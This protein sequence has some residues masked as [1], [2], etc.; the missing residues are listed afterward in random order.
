M[1]EKAQNTKKKLCYRKYQ[2]SETQYHFVFGYPSFEVTSILIRFQ[3]VESKHCRPPIGQSEQV[4]SSSALWGRIS[5]T[6]ICFLSSLLSCCLQRFL[7]QSLFPCCDKQPHMCSA[8]WVLSVWLNKREKGGGG[9]KETRGASRAKGKREQQFV[10]VVSQAVVNS[11][12]R[13]MS[14]NKC[15][16]FSCV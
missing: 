10:Y 5:Q 11:I 7:N 14:L 15:I 4:V 6:L 3:K 1:C 16:S 13:I 2:A 8:L 9:R 12:G